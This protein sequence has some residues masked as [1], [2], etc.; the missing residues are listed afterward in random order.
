MLT[1]V[2]IIRFGGSYLVPY[3]RKERLAFQIPPLTNLCLQPLPLKLVQLMVFWKKTA[4]RDLMRKH[5]DS[6]PQNSLTKP[7]RSALRGGHCNLQGFLCWGHFESFLNAEKIGVCLCECVCACVRAC[8]C[9]CVYVC[10]CVVCVRGVSN[11]LFVCVCVC[12]RACVR[13]CVCVRECVRAWVSVCV[14]ACVCVCV[15]CGARVWSF[16][17]FTWHFSPFSQRVKIILRFSLIVKHAPCVLV[18]F[19]QC[20]AELKQGLNQTITCYNRIE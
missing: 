15:V 9:A 10:V 18:R 5:K 2:W 1:A 13:A 4:E 6:H 19:L 20:T 11:C 8:V 17:S 14:R 12:V 16:S 3:D 7:K